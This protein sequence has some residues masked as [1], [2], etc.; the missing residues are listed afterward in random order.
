MCPPTALV[1]HHHCRG[2]PS[3]GWVG[4]GVM[5]AGNGEENRN[6]AVAGRDTEAD[7]RNPF[8]PPPP[9]RSPFGPA[10]EPQQRSPQENPYGTAP[11][12]DDQISQRRELYEPSD[13]H[14]LAQSPVAQ[15]NRYGTAP[16][17]DEQIRQGRA[18]AALY[19]PSDR[20]TEQR[21]SSAP[22]E[23]KPG[24]RSSAAMAAALASRGRARSAPGAVGSAELSSGTA[25]SA[26]V[27]VRSSAGAES[28]RGR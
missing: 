18:A 15:E 11:S 21:P 13:R 2:R 24:N 26:R 25:G 8:G 28:G 3:R 5:V 19:E 4:G 22:D 7:E 17:I 14:T 20:S 16:P 27:A 10:P 12:I 23:S 9:Q 6:P 1:D